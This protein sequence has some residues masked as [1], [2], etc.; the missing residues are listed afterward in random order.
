MITDIIS[1]MLIRINNG[2]TQKLNVVVVLYSKICLKILSLLYN[3]GYIN[4]YYFTKDGM[5][6]VKLK[7]YLNKN[8]FKNYKRISKPGQR[9]YCNAKELKKKFQ[10]KSFVVVSTVNGLLL[11]KQAILKNTGGEV[12]FMLSFM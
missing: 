6:V 4:G 8:I 9:V 3:E 2:Y 11:H 5:I 7:Y 10:Y 1:D 12:L